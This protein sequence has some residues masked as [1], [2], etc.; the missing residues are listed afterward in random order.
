MHSHACNIKIDI[1]QLYTAMSSQEILSDL[2][3]SA[4]FFG[5]TVAMAVYSEN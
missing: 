2:V 4:A 1:Y 3:C 5:V